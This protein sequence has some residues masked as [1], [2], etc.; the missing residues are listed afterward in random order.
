MKH[1]RRTKDR[2]LLAGAFAAT[3]LASSLAGVPPAQAAH[4]KS[5]VTQTTQVMSEECVQQVKSI[6]A[7]A[8][9]SASTGLDL[10]TATVT[11]TESEVRVATPADMED[12]ATGEGLTEGETAALVARAASG[13][14]MYRNWTHTYWGGSLVENHKGR[15]YWDGSRA[16]IA[17]YRGYA[18]SHSC[19]TEGG[20]AVGWAVTPISCNKPGAGSWADAL[21]RFDASVAFKGSP[22]TLAIG[23]HYSTSATGQTSTWQVGG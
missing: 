16:W 17:S 22:I 3:M 1:P 13:S 10:C 2:P 23:L 6:A 5:A 9:V 8:G 14:I 18:G 7:E 15:T 19:H 11:T 21:Y 12:Y 20:I 4:A